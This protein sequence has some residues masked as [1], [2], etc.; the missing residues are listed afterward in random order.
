MTH[1]MTVV[2]LPAD[3][4]DPAE[5]A[6][7]VMKTFWIIDLAERWDTDDPWDPDTPRMRPGMERFK[8]DGFIIGGRFSG[9]ILGRE[10]HYVMQDGRKYIDPRPEDNICPVSDL[11]AGVDPGAIV[12]PDGSWHEWTRETADTWDDTARELFARHRDCVAVAFDC[13]S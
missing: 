7:E 2:L 3:T 8:C 1:W 4:P 5:R 13:H 6:E 12:T 10:P 11:P 9:A